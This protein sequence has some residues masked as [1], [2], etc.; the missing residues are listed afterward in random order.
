MTLP[1][2]NELDVHVEIDGRTLLAGRAVFTRRGTRIRTVLTYDASYLADRRAYAVAPDQPLDTAAHTID[3]MPGAF[4]DTSPDWWGRNLIS[5]RIRA[6]ALANAEP[7]P[8]VGETDYLLGVSDVTR[9]GALRFTKPGGSTYLG[10]EA[11]V[12]RLVELEELLH[13]SDVVAGGRDDLD[14]DHAV[15]TLLAA[16]TGTLGGARPKASVRDGKQLYIAKFPHPVED[17]WDVMAW[18]KTALDLADRAGIPVPRRRLEQVGGRSVLLLERFD[19]ASRGNDIQR[20][21][22]VSV[23]TLIGGERSSPRDYLDVQAA[24]EDHSGSPNDDL[25]QMWQRMAFSVAIHNTDDH[26]RNYGF[27]RAPHGWNLSPAFDINPNPEVALP[28]ST[29]IGGESLRRGEIKALVSTAPYFGISEKTARKRIAEVFG[30]T[31]A[32]RLVA[33]NNGVPEAEL[34]RFEGAFEGLRA[35]AMKQ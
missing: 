10:A 14:A 25:D 34:A 20:L 9:Q 26:L 4:A 3:G 24:I 21:G 1:Q 13:A 28:R 29:S 35:E 18:E 22:Y 2:R 23:S 31:A 30:A 12:P 27:V 5:R 6:Q 32:W 11:H 33:S 16:G 7:P 8:I 19:R 15:K 17:G